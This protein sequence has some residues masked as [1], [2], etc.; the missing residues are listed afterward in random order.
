MF[1]V[2]LHLHSVFS[3]GQYTPSEIFRLAKEK[4]LTKIAITDH[5]NINGSKELMEHNQEGITLYSG[6]ELTA[7]APK[8]RMHI[9][10]YNID[11]NNEQLNK[12]LNEM[13][14]A[15]IYNI[16]LYIEVLKKDFNIVL[17]N[18][19]VESLLNKKGNIGRP[20]LAVLLIKL[21]YCNSVEEAF[22]KYLIHAY[23]RVRKVKKGLTKEECIDLI[24]S[25][26]GIASLAHPCSLQL[27]DEELKKELLYL[28]SLGLGSIETIHSN[29]NDRERK[30]YH[31]YAQKL[32]LLESGGTDFHG[33]SIK[34]DIMIGSGRNNNVEIDENTLTLTKNIK[35]RYMN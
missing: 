1:K 7:K 12:R 9:L 18:E 8:G 6:V 19:E 21:G 20:Q 30:L 25:S 2:D 34:P 11:L 5:D 33:P 29:E 22:Q 28:K 10:G 23:E 13:H 27:D 14:E 35:S 15:S 4:N 26:G 16:L 32:D 24:I 3:D 31:Q 17:P